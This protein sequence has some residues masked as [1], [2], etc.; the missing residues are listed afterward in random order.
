MHI[1]YNRQTNK[2]KIK[3]IFIVIVNNRIFIRYK[4]KNKIHQF[5]QKKVENIFVIIEKKIDDTFIVIE[6][7]KENLCYHNDIKDKDRYPSTQSR[8][9]KFVF[10]NGGDLTLPYSDKDHLT[11]FDATI[12]RNLYHLYVYRRALIP[13]SKMA[14]A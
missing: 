8:T 4:R 10:V 12:G 6:L 13:C 5:E 7:I 3:V 14:R 2:M 1:L 9:K 11:G